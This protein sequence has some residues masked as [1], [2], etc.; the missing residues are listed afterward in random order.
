M[1]S[2]AYGES[3][4]TV[5]KKDP[6]DLDRVNTGV[7][8]P[9]WLL[10]ELDAITVRNGYRSRNELVVEVLRSWVLEERGRDEPPKR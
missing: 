5:P 9:R 1:E 10:A 2:E 4:P 8:L 7:Q 6:K 3:V